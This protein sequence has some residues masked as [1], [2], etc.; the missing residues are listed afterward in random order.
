M[1][2]FLVHGTFGK[3]FENWF[4]WLEEQ[5]SKIQV[6]CNIPTFPTPNHQQYSDW[7]MLMN[8]Y[9]KVDFFNQ[10]TVLIGH[11]CGAVFIAKYLMIHNIHVKGLVSASGYNN[12]IS[13]FEMMDR[14][15]RS[16]YVKEG[17]VDMHAYADNVYAL[18]GDDDPN[19]PQEYLR[20]F[21]EDIGA[22]TICIPGAGH[23][24]SNSGYLKCDEIFNIITNLI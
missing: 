5:L 7:E 4:P 2:V 19:V 10:E 21:A 12:F 9:N 3:P 1:N 11:S 14:L 24:N 15:N 8:Y 22:D 16:F 6:Q 17:L 13:G 18:F 20:G 23:L